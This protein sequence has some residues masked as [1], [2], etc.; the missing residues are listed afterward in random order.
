MNKKDIALT[1]GG[2]LATMVLAYLFYKMQQ[3]DAAAAITAAQA[4]SDQNAAI[5]TDPGLNAYQYAEALPQI[6]TPQLTGLSTN[7]AA[8]VTNSGQTADLGTYIDAT[9]INQVIGNIVNSFSG[10]LTS[11]DASSSD[12]AKLQIPAITGVATTALSGIPVTAQDA[13]AQA[14]L[15]AAPTITTLDSSTAAYPLEM[16]TGK[17][18]SSHPVTAHPIVTSGS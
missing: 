1:V 14:I 9:D 5:T 3:R 15:T 2:V 18:V 4:V 17:H 11:S 6:S 12:L 8:E 16:V 7:T 13:A 10:A